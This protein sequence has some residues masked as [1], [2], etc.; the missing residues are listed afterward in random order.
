MQ[1]FS[2]RLDMA[3]LICSSSHRFRQSLETILEAMGCPSAASVGDAA[4]ARQ[5]SQAQ[6]FDIAIVD[7]SFEAFETIN[8]PA[9][10]LASNSQTDPAARVLAKPFRPADLANMLTDSLAGSSAETALTHAA[11]S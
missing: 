6:P 3:V 9:I 2:G 8:L 5:Q 11:T 10:R 7:E 4:E 1:S